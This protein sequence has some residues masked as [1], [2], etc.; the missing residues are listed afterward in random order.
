MTKPTTRQELIDYAKRQLGEPVVEVNIADSQAEDCLDDAIQKIHNEHSDGTEK[1][2]YSYQ[3]TQT[4]IDN[5][6]I[7]NFDSD[8]IEVLRVFPLADHSGNINLFDSK[9]R[10]LLNDLYTMDNTQ[11]TGWVVLNQHLELIDDLLNPEITLEF[12]RYKNSVKFRDTL[13][14]TV[15]A[16]EYL[17]FEV[18]RVI[19][20]E[21]YTAVYNDEFLKKYLIQLIKRQWANNLRKYSGFQLPGGITMDADNLYQEAQEEILRLEEELEEKYSEPPGGFIG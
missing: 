17:L 16:G 3:L 6:E 18:Y 14:H 9:Q 1:T 13:K 5:N 7:S 12:S 10:M 15:S 4:D 20:P 19:D 21:T 2:L 11:L 8:I